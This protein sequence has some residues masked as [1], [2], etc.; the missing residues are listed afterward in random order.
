VQLEGYLAEARERARL[1]ARATIALYPA[2]AAS[3][4]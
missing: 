1:A 2:P 3:P 4:S